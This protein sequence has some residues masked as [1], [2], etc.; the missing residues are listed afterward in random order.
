ML[1]RI[2]SF[3]LDTIINDRPNPSVL[4]SEKILQEIINFDDIISITPFSLGGEVFGHYKNYFIVVVFSLEILKIMRLVIHVQKHS[5]I[6]IFRKKKQ[7]AVLMAAVPVFRNSFVVSSHTWRLFRLQFNEIRKKIYSSSYI[8]YSIILLMKN[9]EQIIFLQFKKFLNSL[10]C[11]I[12]KRYKYFHYKYFR[13]PPLPVVSVPS[14]HATL[15][16]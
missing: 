6:Q 2:K 4:M 10:C 16:Q 1:K 3:L 12:F 13:F 9:N 5:G 15:Q 11:T 8:S 14:T 7:K